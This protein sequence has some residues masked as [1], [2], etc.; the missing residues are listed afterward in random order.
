LLEA[1]TEDASSKVLPTTAEV[2]PQL[3]PTRSSHLRDTIVTIFGVVAWN[4][5][6]RARL[7]PLKADHRLKLNWTLASRIKP[8]VLSQGKHD[9][10][11]HLHINRADT[12]VVHR[13]ARGSSGITARKPQSSAN[14]RPRGARD[15]CSAVELRLHE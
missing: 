10:E 4:I 5:Q 6:V 7:L 12:R 2:D 14:I 3:N 9:A 8:G 13:V 1:S 15:Y 11:T